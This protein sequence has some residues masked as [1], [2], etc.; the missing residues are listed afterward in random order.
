[1]IDLGNN[2]GIDIGVARTGGRRR[3]MSRG[4][5]FTHGVGKA[6]AIPSF[7]DKKYAFLKRGTTPS[8][9][10]KS[11]IHL[12]LPGTREQ[13]ATL[14]LMKERAKRIQWVIKG[15]RPLYVSPE[16]ARMCA[17]RWDF[18]QPR[19]GIAALRRQYDMSL[20]TAMVMRER[21]LRLS[22]SPDPLL[23]AVPATNVENVTD[24]SH[25]TY[26]RSYWP[27]PLKDDGPC[28]HLARLF[29]AVRALLA[30]K[31]PPTTLVHP[32]LMTIVAPEDDTAS[33]EED[34][35]VPAS[36][37]TDETESVAEP[38]VTRSSCVSLKE[39]SSPSSIRS[40]MLMQY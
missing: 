35:E 37:V 19:G 1:M 12:P 13:E 25:L 34:S 14:T 2:T 27:V 24:N 15:G 31:T 10:V 20:G 8:G 22:P 11:G 39:I 4:V 9:S 40:R 3:G 7:V 5:V 29:P 18:S 38:R 21:E 16:E 33:S 23:N 30:A 28:C 17:L 32:P 6:A 36:S 26:V